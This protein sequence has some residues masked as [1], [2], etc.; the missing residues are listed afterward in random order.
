MRDYK[1]IISMMSGTSL[2]GIDACLLRIYDNLKFEIIDSYSL[3]YP[4]EI[5]AKLLN[6]ANN[7]ATVS[8]VCFMN[9][10]LGN[11]FAEAANKLI[12]K[13]NYKKEDID[14]ILV[15]E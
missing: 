14:F 2:D 1:T 10:V 5:K 12:V 15:I 7:S 11:L 4:T 9:F 8:D 13:S 3:D 6:I